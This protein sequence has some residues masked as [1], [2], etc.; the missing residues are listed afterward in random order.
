LA[1]VLH[2]DGDQPGVDLAIHKAMR[3]ID[4]APVPDDWVYKAHCA[5]TF[6]TLGELVRLQGNSLLASRL[7]RRSQELFSQLSAEFPHSTEYRAQ[8]AHVESSL[9]RLLA[10]ESV[11][12]SLLSPGRL[13]L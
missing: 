13:S 3:L 5:Y 12:P 8:R 2:A 4:G 6:L 1:W 7:L 9:R 10:P 11:T